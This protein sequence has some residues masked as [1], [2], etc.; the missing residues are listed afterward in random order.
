MNTYNNLTLNSHNY[1]RNVIAELLSTLSVIGF[2]IYS[3]FEILNKTAFPIILALGSLTLTVVLIVIQLRKK[4]L[5]NQQI[6][7]EELKAKL[8]L[9]EIEKVQLETTQQNYIFNKEIEE[10]EKE[11][12]KKD[13]ISNVSPKQN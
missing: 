11:K 2:N 5:I 9:A 13:V 6:K 3:I 10:E 7:C 8:T 12:E 1:M 4:T